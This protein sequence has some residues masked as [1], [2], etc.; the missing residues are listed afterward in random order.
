MTTQ[1]AKNL[2]IQSS[3]P[4]IAHTDFDD[5]FDSVDFEAECQEDNETKS[6]PF[7]QLCT[8]S[9][10]LTR[11]AAMPDPSKDYPYGLFIPVSQAEKAGF[12]PDDNWMLES[13]CL[14]GKVRKFGGSGSTPGYFVKP[15]KQARIV[16]LAQSVQEVYA[17]KEFQG[18]KS[19][20]CLGPY[21]TGFDSDGQPIKSDAGIR[22]DN[23]PKNTG[24]QNSQRYLF[25][26]VGQDNEPLSERPFSLR[27]SNAFGIGFKSEMKM[28]LTE[29]IA[30]SR[31]HSEMKKAEEIAK[32]EKAKRHAIDTLDVEG[33]I[34]AE[35]ALKVAKRK[36]V[37][38][39]S[40]IDQSRFVFVFGQS[41]RE[42][43]DGIGT[44]Y[45][46]GRAQPSIWQG[47]KPEPFSIDR[48]KKSGDLIYSIAIEPTAYPRLFVKAGSDFGKQIAADLETYAD[49]KVA[50]NL[51]KQ[52]GEAPVVAKMPDFEP[53]DDYSFEYVEEELT[54]IEGD[55]MFASTLAHLKRAIDVEQIEK[56]RQWA[57]QPKQS[58]SFGESHPTYADDLMTL[59][60]RHIKALPVYA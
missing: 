8:T 2:E 51:R 1:K 14:G 60:A 23:A 54:A 27:I 31:I 49:Y 19:K 38:A 57:L 42:N 22:F 11:F 20:S 55:P 4:A 25:Y 40:R 33:G 50:P 10:D 21:L 30:A 39:L 28:N 48:T 6:I 5:E 12:T 41:M 46:S 36:A 13:P 18:K 53:A 56:W 59:A 44:T 32:A 15:G 29:M 17:D 9:V 34:A 7:A 26:V 47:E 45:L 58:G 24:W 35:T 52:I 37:R 3:A 16:V 43:K